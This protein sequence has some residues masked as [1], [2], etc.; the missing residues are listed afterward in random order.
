MVQIEVFAIK[1][2]AAV[3]TNILVPLENVK[4]S[5]LHFLF[6]QSVKQNEQ[7]YFWNADP[8]GYRV[9]AFGMRLAF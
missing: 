3:L 9:N 8:E 5:E 7:D 4:S 1:G 2:A 6:R